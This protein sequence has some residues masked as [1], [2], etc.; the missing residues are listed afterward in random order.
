MDSYFISPKRGKRLRSSHWL[1][2]SALRSQLLLPMW[3][4]TCT[5][6][7]VRGGD[8]GLLSEPNSS[9]ALPPEGPGMGE[10]LVLVFLALQTFCAHSVGWWSTYAL[11]TARNR[12]E[13]C[14]L[15]RTVWAS[16]ANPT[17]HGLWSLRLQRV[18]TSV[19][20]R[21]VHGALSALLLL[22]LLH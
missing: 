22:L 7:K 21:R 6:E 8:T 16:P 17:C 5:M 1:L 9:S 12:R 19:S 20:M 4:G 3:L 10:F 18:A 2:P 15:H 13:G 11:L 14:H